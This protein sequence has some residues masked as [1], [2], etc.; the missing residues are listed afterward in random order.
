M[1]N[2]SARMRLSE[3]P[4]ERLLNLVRYGKINPRE[5]HE[6]AFNELKLRHNLLSEIDRA[7]EVCPTDHGFRI[8]LGDEL[9]HLDV[10][11]SDNIYFVHDFF[12]GHNSA[13]Q[14]LGIGSVM[15][16]KLKYVA[17]KKGARAIFLLSSQKNLDFYTHREVVSLYKV[18]GSDYTCMGIIF[19]D[20]LRR[21]LLE[22]AGPFGRTLSL[23]EYNLFLD[24]IGESD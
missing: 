7:L 6:L 21:K 17:K 18:E 11:V 10:H 2:M 13:V 9:C 3:T 22:K 14:G 24:Y 5:L 20:A 16:N 12:V 23:T 8:I 15:F 1:I 19:D 4:R